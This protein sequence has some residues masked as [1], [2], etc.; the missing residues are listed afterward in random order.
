MVTHPWKTPPESAAVSARATHVW[1]V[2][3]D[4]RSALGYCTSLLSP[5]ETARAARF[6]FDRDR[7][8]YVIARGALRDVL[9]R[10][11]GTPPARLRFIYNE[12]G[13]PAL[14]PA[15]CAFNLSHSGDIAMIAL[16]SQAPVGVDVEQ[17]SRQVD[18]EGL[19]E[20]FFCPAE[21]D[22]ILSLDGEAR[23]RAFFNGW[24]RKEA[25]L[26]ARG[27]GVTLGLQTFEVSVHPE[28]PARL[29]AV[30]GNAEAAARW[31]LHALEPAPGYAAAVA[32][33]G[34]VEETACW[35][36]AADVPRQGG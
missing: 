14:E 22:V 16:S 21:A 34:Q 27:I 17:V 6:R 8:R 23:R 1:R 10:Y 2:E 25:L 15:G 24:T 20:R 32:V 28:E 35:I 5:D 19:A 9:S 36:W 29:V 18:I 7:D 3:L 31:S 12:F 4:G 33:E 26:K 13:K 30:N 11:T